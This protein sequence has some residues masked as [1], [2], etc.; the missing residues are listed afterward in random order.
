MAHT[1]LYK[2]E[3]SAV[4]DY[5]GD[6]DYYFVAKNYADNNPDLKVAFGYNKVE[7]WN[8]YK[9]RGNQEGR[10]V[11]G[12]SYNVDAKLKVFDTAASI[13]NDK[14][15]EQDKIKEVHDWI[16][17]HTRYDKENF[18]NNTIPG[19]SYSMQESHARW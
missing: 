7:L 6:G 1:L 4:F 13:T 18:F 8:H 10:P 11:Y 9:T 14:M 3:R 15:S 17:N 2:P 19:T 16:V 5:R 12:A